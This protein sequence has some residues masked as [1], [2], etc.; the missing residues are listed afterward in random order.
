MLR[1]VPGLA[2]LRRAQPELTDPR[3]DRNV[4]D[5]DEDER[6]LLVDRSGLR[7]AV[8]MSDETR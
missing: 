8:N 6:W 1:A 3:F 2:A 7:I 5:F 4:V